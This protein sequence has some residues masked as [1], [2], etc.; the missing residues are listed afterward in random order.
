LHLPA[1]PA[2]HPLPGSIAMSTTSHSPAAPRPASAKPAVGF[3]AALAAFLI[4]GIAPLYFKAVEPAGA[5]E[6][7][8][9]RVIW[10][11]V[12]LAGLVAT[13]GRAGAIAAEFR[14]PARL[15]L[16]LLTT[17]LITNNWLIYIHAV[18]VDEVLQASLGYFINP[19]VNVLL[20]VLFLAERLNR[21][22]LAAVAL[23]AAGVL[24]QVVGYGAVPWISLALAFSFGFYALLRKKAVVDPFVGLLVETLL[25]TPL[26][27]GYLIVLGAAGGS[28]FLVGDPAMDLLLLAAGLVTGAPLILFMIGAQRLTLSAIGL[29]QYLAPTLQF[30]LAVAVFGEPLNSGQMVTFAG[31]WLGL[32]IYSWDAISRYRGSRRQIP[33]PGPGAD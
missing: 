19:L 22:Q 14:R 27:L 26:A 13:M 32:A 24:Y 16:Y 33:A 21:R 5:L 10:T 11:A 31:I 17:A 30:V 12:L 29:M 3:A 28:H 9:H 23:A 20:G 6:I 1:P 2:R 8:A 15:G 18:L 7:L 25:L 4:W